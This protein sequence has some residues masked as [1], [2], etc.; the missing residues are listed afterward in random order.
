MTKISTF[1]LTLF[2]HNMKLYKFNIIYRHTIYHFE[3]KN[4]TISALT[5]Q[6]LLI[7]KNK[8]IFFIG[9]KTNDFILQR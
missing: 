8:I 7:W 6:I 9:I 1:F 2:K 4:I 3:H 5:C